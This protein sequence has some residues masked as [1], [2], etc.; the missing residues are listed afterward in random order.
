VASE[1]SRKERWAAWSGIVAAL[2]LAAALVF[3]G[4]QAHDSAAAQRQAKLATELGLL[5]QIQS[6]MS[7][8]VYSRV[9]YTA[10]FRELRTGQRG[11]LSRQAY[12]VTAEEAANM[13][14][15]AWLFN[16]G[17]LKAEGA[18]ELLGPRMLCEYQQAFAPTFK[19]PA[20]DVPNLVLF[21]QER[22]L[23]LSKLAKDC[24]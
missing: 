23:K 15:F 13:D 4:I 2:S 10:Q 6:S 17:Y 22:R 9:P 20:H 21:L 3:N 24:E 16:N 7:K 12:R 5:A 1:R 11:A 8:S 18:D 14:Y 19:D